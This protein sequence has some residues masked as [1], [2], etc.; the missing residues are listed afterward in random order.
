MLN[1]SRPQKLPL[2]SVN[3]RANSRPQKRPNSAPWPVPTAAARPV[4]MRPLT[5]ST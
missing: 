1:A 5:L 3:S 4:V 2:S